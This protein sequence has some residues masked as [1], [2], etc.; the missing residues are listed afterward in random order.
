MI[1]TPHFEKC[2][3]VAAMCVDQPLQVRML[4][5]VQEGSQWFGIMIYVCHSISTDRSVL[6][7]FGGAVWQ[8]PLARSSWGQHPRQTVQDLTSQS[9]DSGKATMKAYL[10]VRMFN[11]HVPSNRNTSISLLQ[12]EM[13]KKNRTKEQ[14]LL[15]VE[16]FPFIPLVF[17]AQGGWLSN[18]QPLQDSCLPPCGQVGPA[19]QCDTKLATLYS[20]IFSTMSSL[21]CIRDTHSSRGHTIYLDPPIDL[22]NME[23]QLHQN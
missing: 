13:N 11:P 22:V 4:C 12:D 18:A 5:P 8:P 9:I 7:C 6:L 15:E 3:K 23:A 14:H 1:K 16:H 17:S 2:E 10:D 20:V 21:Q 19:V